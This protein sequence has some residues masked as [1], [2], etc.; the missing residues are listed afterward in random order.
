MTASSLPSRSTHRF[1]ARVSTSHRV[2]LAS[3][4]VAIG[5]SG[6]AVPEAFANDLIDQ[7]GYMQGVDISGLTTLEQDGAVY[8]NAQ[9]VPGDAIGLFQSAGLDWYRL[10]LFVNPNGQGMVTNDL[11]Y[12][13][14]LAQRIKSAGG[15]FLLDLHYSDTWADPGNQNIPAAWSNQNFNQ[16][17]NQV[18]TYT[19]D[20]MNAFHAQGAKPDMV[21]IGNEISAGM[22][23]PHG[24]LFTSGNDQADFNRLTSLI[25]AGI[26]GVD[27]SNGPDTLKMVHVA[28]GSDAWLGNFFIS[29]LE[30]RNVDFD[31]MGFS[32]YPRYHGS[33]EDVRSN[34][35]QLA[36]THDVPI[37][38][39]EIGFA[40]RGA[41]WEPPQDEFEVSLD[42]QAAFAREVSDLVK[43]LPNDLGKGV[44]WWHGEAVPT[45]S[46]LAWNGGRLGLF[47]A[48][49]RLAPA[50]FEI[51]STVTRI[52]GD[53]NG[54]GVVGLLDLDILGANWNTA[55]YAYSQGDFNADGVVSLLDLDILG[56]QWHSG[57][58]VAALSATGLP[59]PEPS[60]LIPAA[61]GLL[62]RRRATA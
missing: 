8:R 30:Q 45:N 46:G 11:N 54:D 51:G 5:L 28:D 27:Q 40:N 60:F 47:D 29:N 33:I 55:T 56:S 25:E 61:L 48:Q 20:V 18:E 36:L 62:I 13:I 34:L 9:G 44:F 23:W 37:A 26:S 22:L 21:Q 41:Q 19:R 50:A 42:G 12:T 35:N 16:L 7:L 24:Q 6:S 57:S 53:A 49:S 1:F 2:G 58:F 15:N 3:A 43:D 38:L 32:Y 10:R 4:A 14:N 52:P 17:T 39:A 31:I 59:V